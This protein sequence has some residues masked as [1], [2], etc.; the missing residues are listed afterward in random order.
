MAGTNWKPSDSLD[1]TV[2]AASAAAASVRSN[3]RDLVAGDVVG[4][5]VVEELLGQGGMGQVYS[6]LH[7][8]IG[9]K[10]AIKVLRLELCMAA[11][12]VERFIREA[13]AVNQIGHPNIV[14]IFAF[15]ELADHRSYFVMEK[16]TGESLQARME[17]KRLSRNEVCSIGES[18]ASALDA[19]HE[20]Q[21]IHRDLKPENIFLQ[22]VRGKPSTV[23]LLDFGIAK[24]TGDDEQRLASTRTGAML[25]TPMYIA[26]E[27]ARGLRIDHRVDIYSLGVL[28]F[29][30]VV[31]RLP[32]QAESAMDLVM[33]HINEAPPTLAS[34]DPSVPPMLDALVDQM[35]AKDPK[36][37]PTLARCAKY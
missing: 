35:L 19:A 30:M 29:E 37:R 34:V 23:K 16:L 24:L 8:L 25:G 1:Q 26:P 22:A 2:D 31:G 33:K 6:A 9:K 18:I 27:Q 4:E 28:L 20:K 36:V 13:R 5:Y 12:S 10:A 15:G 21:I 32:F 3:F 14:D 11:E 17:R 7:P